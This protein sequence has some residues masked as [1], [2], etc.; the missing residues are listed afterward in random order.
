MH[1]TAEIPHSKT[2]R[3]SL[4]LLLLEDNEAAAESLLRQLRLAGFDPRVQ[5]VQTPHELCHRVSARDVDLIL[6]DCSLPSWDGTEALEL[7]QQMEKDVPVIFLASSVTEEEMR[8]CLSKG[9]A[10]YV[11]KHCLASL[12]GMVQ[13]VLELKTLRLEKLRAEARCREAERQQQRWA[14]L[15]S[16]P[17]FMIR[18]HTIVFANVAASKLLGFES[19]EQLLGLP[20][21]SLVHAEGRG[22]FAEEVEALE[23][24][25]DTALL[26][27][28]LLR[29]D[30][31]PLPVKVA[32]VGLTYRGKPAVQFSARDAAER[33]RVEEAIQSLAAFAQFNPNPVLEFSRDGQLTYCNDAASELARSLGLDH[34]RA[35]LPPQTAALVQICLATGQKRA[36]VETTVRGRTFSWLFFPIQENQVVHCYV[37]DV[38]DRQTLEAQLRHSQRLESVG[39]LAA[40]VAHDFNNIL[41]VIQGHTGLLRAHPD[42][43]PDMAESV[44]QVSRAAERAGKLTGQLLAFS[45]KNLLQP[46]RLD[47]NDVITSI[48]TLLHRTLGEDINYQFSYAPDLPPVF[49]D[50]ALLEQ[51]IMNLSV[52]ARDAMPRGGQLVLSTTLADVDMLHVER[53]PEARPGR[54]VCLTMIDSGCG[55]DHVTLSRIFEPFFT[56]KEFGKGTGL[57]LAVVYGIIKQHHG[58]IEVMSQMGQGTTFR[59]YLPPYESSAEPAPETV[60]PATIVGGTETI[61]LVEDESPVRWTVR[62]VLERYGYRV[63]E[64]AAG[65]EALAVW[66]QHQNDI[67]LLLTDVVMPAGLTGQELA[68]KFKF[69]KPDLKV[70]YTSGYSVQVAGKGL[71]LLDGLTFL[72]KPF[73]AEKLALAVR[74]CLDSSK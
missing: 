66:H 27:T 57:G 14:E 13:H 70:I 54:F 72:Q 45:R 2:T 30:S 24:T 1:L 21:P 19:P 68:D 8:D 58:W 36:P 11:D 63:L 18:A 12:P 69:Q 9:A 43:K 37:T 17:L 20:A 26:E 4:N 56:T 5:R 67:A 42:I 31:K 29:A 62:N 74:K 44:Q 53:H 40:G 15:S 35:F 71:H 32:A 50:A 7:L 46:R 22:A 28:K 47:L 6:A 34:P 10:G 39:R 49:A 25:S 3:R 33:K 41:T 48:S 60:A 23:G 59:V 16:E 64:A 61:L 38:T 52:N 51:V 73:D 55:M 65:V